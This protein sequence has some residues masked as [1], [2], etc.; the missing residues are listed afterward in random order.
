MSNSLFAQTKTDNTQNP[1]DAIVEIS[2]TE[3]D[4]EILLYNDTPLHK[5]NFLK[6]VSDGFYDGVLFHRVIKDFMVQTG[7]PDSKQAS[8]GQSLGAGDPGYQIDA[9]IIYPKH[10][11]KYG[12]LAAARTG[13]EINPEKKSSG[14]QFYIVTGNK[15][16]ETTLKNITARRLDQ[17]RQAYFQQQVRKN[18]SLIQTLTQSNDTVALENLRMKLIN[19]TMQALPE[20]NIPAE[21]IAAYQEVGGTPFLDDDYTVFGEVIKGMDVVEK[22]QNAPTGKNDRPTS[23]IKI[24]SA[25]VKECGPKK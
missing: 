17:K 1:G 12:A 23:D 13:D 2:T 5:T 6:L 14:S 7:D 25:K 4:I 8:A 11:H 16:D 18:G 15:Y 10:F 20:T 21:V 24:I 19:E 3:G 9:E 22:I